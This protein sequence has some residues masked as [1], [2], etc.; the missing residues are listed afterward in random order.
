MFT[1][2]HGGSL[3]WRRLCPSSCVF[4]RG[5]QGPSGE[6]SKGDQLVRQGGDGSDD[7]ER[8]ESFEMREELWLIPLQESSR[9]Q[10]LSLPSCHHC[11]QSTHQAS[12]CLQCDTVSC[13]K[14][15]S[16]KRIRGASNGQG[17]SARAPS[18]APPTKGK[19]KKVVVDH[20]GLH[21][22]ASGHMFCTSPFTPQSTQL[23][24]HAAV[25]GLTGTIY[26]HRC[27]DFVYAE[28]IDT[29]RNRALRTMEERSDISHD[30]SSLLFGC[31][32]VADGRGRTWEEGKVQG[33]EA[34]TGRKSGDREERSDTM[35]LYVRRI[36]SINLH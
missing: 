31:G 5:N 1:Q 17:D 19:V 26:C 25:D 10:K 27:E 6:I 8:G 32:I 35:S 30:G 3:G 4:V 22:K 33:V 13:R 34:F 36:P 24:H 21:A 15:I 9:R 14:T 20:P 7:G 29:W 23:T 28:I 18:R 16:I 2:S 12:V 11:K